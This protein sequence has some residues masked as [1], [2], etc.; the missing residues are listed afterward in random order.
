M[1][2]LLY[3]QMCLII[4]MPNEIINDLKVGLIVFVYVIFLLFRFD[5]GTKN[6]QVCVFATFCE[7]YPDVGLHIEEALLNKHL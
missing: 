2:I 1:L 7:I 4:T 6:D 5:F 3:R